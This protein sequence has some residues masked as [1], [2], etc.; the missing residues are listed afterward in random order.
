MARNSWDLWP[1]FALALASLALLSLFITYAGRSLARV[2]DDVE[3]VQG[4]RTTQT[5]AF[6]TLPI[7]LGLLPL[8]G[9]VLGMWSALGSTQTETSRGALHTIGALLSPTDLA[10]AVQKLSAE[11]GYDDVNLA[12]LDFKKIHKRLEFVN[13]PR[14]FSN[15]DQMLVTVSIYI[16]MAICAAMGPVLIALY[17]RAPRLEIFEPT[18]R[19]FHPLITYAVGFAFVALTALFACQ[20]LNAGGTPGFDFTQIPRALGALAIVNINLISLVYLCS[21]LTRW[22]DRHT[23]SLLAPLLS[24]RR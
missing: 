22:S 8:L 1:Q 24:A 19:A 5:V 10:Q 16:G 14:M 3:L 12:E 9:A 2:A 15:S 4:K 7:V 20:Y 13:L 23:F 17:G 6:R 21:L 11:G 18:D